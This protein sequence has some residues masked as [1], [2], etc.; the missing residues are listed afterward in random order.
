M[1]AKWRTPDSYGYNEVFMAVS[2]VVSLH[3]EAALRRRFGAAVRPA[4]LSVRARQ[5]RGPGDM[6]E[7]FRLRD[8]GHY[9]LRC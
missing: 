6:P 5:V 7:Q 9:P 4:R 2:A 1:D 8:R 3:L